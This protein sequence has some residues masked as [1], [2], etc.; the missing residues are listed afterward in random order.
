VR[1][2]GAVRDLALRLD[3]AA[4]LPREP[5]AGGRADVYLVRS[6]SGRVR[7]VIA[8]VQVVAAGTED[9]VATATV[10]VAPVDVPRLIA[11][12]TAGNL[13]LVARLG[14]R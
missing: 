6:G 9:G 13:R 5:V 14:A 8:G 11:A 2:R 10:R 3:D 4:G 1:T 7:L 12:E